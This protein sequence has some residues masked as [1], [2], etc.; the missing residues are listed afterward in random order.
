MTELYCSVL[1]GVLVQAKISSATHLHIGFGDHL[2]LELH[3]TEH[4]ADILETSERCTYRHT[5]LQ[6]QLCESLTHLLQPFGQSDIYTV[7]L[8]IFGKE[9]GHQ[10]RFRRRRD[11]LHLDVF[12]LDTAQ[13]KPLQRLELVLRAF[14]RNHTNLYV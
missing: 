4:I 12:T 3:H 6:L 13:R 2:A 9:E 5:A 8:G 14:E 11:M 10:R 7:D 1:Y